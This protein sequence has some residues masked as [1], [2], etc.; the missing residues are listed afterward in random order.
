MRRC[1]V[2]ATVDVFHTMMEAD[3]DGE[4]YSVEFLMVT[5]KAGSTGVQSSVVDSMQKS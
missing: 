4:S 3:L 5:K 2:K 1:I